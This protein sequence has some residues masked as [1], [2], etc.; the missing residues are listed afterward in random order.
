LATT[1][2][3][4]ALTTARAVAAA[5]TASRHL[6]PQRVDARV[7]GRIALLPAPPPVPAVPGEDA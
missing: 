5:W 2:R 3:A 4:E 6:S 7:V 1:H